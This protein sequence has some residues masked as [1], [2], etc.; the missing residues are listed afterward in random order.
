ML[1]AKVM[2]AWLCP[3]LDEA[4]VVVEVEPM[5]GIPLWSLLPELLELPHPANARAAPT[6]TAAV[7]ARPIV[8]FILVVSLSVVV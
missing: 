4:E 8:I 7:T 5:P 3:L 6:L 2:S 1:A